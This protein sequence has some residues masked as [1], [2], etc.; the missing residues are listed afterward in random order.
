VVFVGRAESRDENEA[1]FNSQSKS[2]FPG[3][4][5]LLQNLDLNPWREKE[6][7]SEI[8]S[9]DCSHVARST[10]HSSTFTRR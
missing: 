2:E 9:H 7:E 1:A 4:K 10:R 3:M 6:R 8:L 5:A